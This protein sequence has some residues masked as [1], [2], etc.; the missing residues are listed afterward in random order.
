[1]KIRV[2][3]DC[4]TIKG[5]IVVYAV[6]RVIDMPA[7]EAKRLVTAGVAEFVEAPAVEDPDQPDSRMGGRG[8]RRMTSAIKTSMIR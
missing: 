6:P 5:R 1:M 8:L 2:L 7:E 3:E 4:D